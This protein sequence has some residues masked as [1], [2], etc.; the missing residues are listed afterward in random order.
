MPGFSSFR[1]VILL[2]VLLT[3]TLL[4]SAERQR[5]ARAA[6]QRGA[7]FDEVD[8]EAPV[9]EAAEDGPSEEAP[10]D[11]PKT[12]RSRNA[13]SK[14]PKAKADPVKE[15]AFRQ[16]QRSVLQQM[17]NKSP[18]VRTAAVRRLADHPTPDAARLLIDQGLA[19]DF[20]DV[21]E[22]AYET[23]LS[24]KNAEEVTTALMNSVE[25]DIKRGARRDSTG[26]MLSVALAS[27][28]AG[29][30]DRA[31]ELLDAAV[32]QPKGGLLL[33]VSLADALGAEAGETSL[34]TLVKISQRPIFGDQFA[35]RR[36]VVQAMAKI[37]SV[38]AIDALVSLLP[39]VKGEV[40]GDIVRRLTEV[41]GEHF[42]LDAERWTEWWKQHQDDFD[43][44]GIA[45][46]AANRTA[47]PPSKS[48][49]YGMPIYAARVV[50][51]LD[52]SRSMLRDG[53]IVAAKRELTAAIDRLPEG[54]YFGVLAFNSR[55]VPWQRKLV[56]ASGEN[57]QRAA[58]FV[59]RQ[60]LGNSTASYD[61][62]EAAFDYDT[63]AVFFLTDGAPH[64][65]KVVK[66]EEIV[67]VI[68]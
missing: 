45:E 16:V 6:R 10:A 58:G 63:E 32:K 12:S 29:T 26:T 67:E 23:L 68:T 11:K 62:L 52:T 2:A 53:R 57:K 40:R 34:A 5:T 38:D 61:A 8:K 17:R 35:V 47:A 39:K 14:E 44:P 24:Y 13:R 28:E 7:P 1:P 54:V 22:A 21:R 48:S 9:G 51:V 55:V 20:D 19:S 37:R 46:M 66:P 65:G 25:K 50:F 3:S 56:V 18:E 41:S 31:F 59:E 15:K 60:D 42:E 43:F 36:S 33:V 64:G 4:W 27:D 30:L 49:Y